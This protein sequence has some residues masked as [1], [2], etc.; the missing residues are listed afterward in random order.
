MEC[1]VTAAV[2]KEEVEVDEEGVNE[3]E[4]AEAAFTLVAVAVEIQLPLAVPL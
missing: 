1:V 4:V 3:E 2:G